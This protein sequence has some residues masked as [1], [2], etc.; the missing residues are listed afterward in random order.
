MNKYHTLNNYLIN[1]NE[2]VYSI[3]NYIYKI[4]ELNDHKNIDLSLMNELMNYVFYDTYCVT[5]E[6]FVKY[7]LLSNINNNNIDNKMNEL[8]YQNKLIEGE[9]Y[10]YKNNNYY[11]H[12]DA[13]KLCLM[14]NSCYNKYYLLLEESIISYHLYLK[15]YNDSVIS[16]KNNDIILLN[17]KINILLKN[18]DKII[19]LIN[20]IHEKK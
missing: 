7:K 15:M 2:E 6:V 13:F 10:V 8:I 4:N 19:D 11:F 20:T 14:K 3:I 5:S 18:N 1:N 12:S 9:D 17:N 16:K